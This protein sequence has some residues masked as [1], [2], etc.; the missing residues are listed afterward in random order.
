MLLLLLVIAGVFSATAAGLATGRQAWTRSAPWLPILAGLLLAVGL[1]IEAPRATEGPYGK[2]RVTLERLTVRLASEQAATMGGDPLRDDVVLSPGFGAAALRIG[3]GVLPQ[4]FLRLER[5]GETL[6]LSMATQPASGSQAVIFVEDSSGGRFLGALPMEADQVC[7]AR[8]RANDRTLAALADSRVYSNDAIPVLDRS[9]RPIQSG[10]GGFVFT[11]GD[12]KVH[13]VDR[14]LASMDRRVLPKDAIGVRLMVFEAEPSSP[15]FINGEARPGRLVLRRTFRLDWDGVSLVFRPETP[16]AS[17]LDLDQTAEGRPVVRFAAGAA[18]NTPFGDDQIVVAFSLLG[19]SFDGDLAARTIDI[20]RRSEE[21]STLHQPDGTQ[22]LFDKGIV[23]GEAR[24]ISVRIDPLDFD[25]GLYSMVLPFGALVLL[26][27][28]MSTYDLRREDPVAALAFGLV[29]FLLVMRLLVALEGAFVDVAA[30]AQA[31][32]PAAVIALP[33]GCFVALAV[34]PQAPSRVRALIGLGS[35]TFAAMALTAAAGSLVK[36]LSILGVL[37][38][39]G[40]SLLV[41]IRDKPERLRGIGFIGTWWAQRPLIV[42][43]AGT[44]VIVLLRLTFVVGGFKEGVLLPGGS[45]LALSL[46][47]V[48]LG[49]LAF[50]PLIAQAQAGWNDDWWMRPFP[51]KVERVIR[52]LRVRPWPE[53]VKRVTPWLCALPNS[54]TNRLWQWSWIQGDQPER[55]AVVGM[56]LGVALAVGIGLASALAN[57]NGFVIFA[58]PLILGAV[59]AAAGQA[60]SRR[61]WVADVVAATIGAALLLAVLA[62]MMGHDGLKLALVATGTGVAIGLLILRPSALWQLPAAVVLGLLILVNVVAAIGGW[63][64]GDL[65]I[66]QAIIG[67][68]NDLRLFAALDPARLSQVGTRGSEG[69][70]DAIAHMRAYGDTFWGRGYFT[71]PAPTVLRA[72]HLT[73]NAAAV[74]LV[75]PFGRLGAAAFMVG[76]AALAFAACCVAGRRSTATVW[77]GALAALTLATVSAY[78]ILANLLAAPFTGRN[79]YLLAP[80]STADL[81]EGLLLIALVVLTLGRPRVPEAA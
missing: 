35:A 1:W 45:R 34:H 11:G 3:R 15:A 37:I 58:L 66:A 56:A 24:Q 81:L 6:V 18:A 73:D 8:C 70:Q 47:F 32:L 64:H 20:A 39:V 27:S 13:V 40:L 79:V 28:F 50:A 21:R 2:V 65:S 12:G 5:R 30:K 26:I 61:T 38:L 44:A 43:L 67:E 23:L 80:W 59:A 78:M 16:Q 72:Y 71:L 68:D 76:P 33:L 53:K 54:L 14:R 46:I 10:Q 25:T 63:S 62:A 60:R 69:L 9:G 7:L 49:L 55:W 42:L 31:A 75:S 74:H 52:W 57:D 17:L 48:P 51:A 77:L 4:S 22:I 29:E 41:W 36:D 19:A